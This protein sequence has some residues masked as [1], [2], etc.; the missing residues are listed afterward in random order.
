MPVGYQGTITDSAFLC[1]LQVADSFFPIGSFSHSYGLETF[2]QE[3]VITSA[4]TLK[5]FMFTYIRYVLAHTDCLGVFLTQKYALIRDFDSIVHLDQLMTALKN[6]YE[7][8][9]AST[10]IG[11]AMLN[12]AQQHWVSPLLEKYSVEVSKGVAHCNHAVVFG[13]I[14][15]IIGLPPL[16]ANLVFLYNT[17]ASMVNAAIKLVPLGQREGQSVLFSL[18]PLII[19]TANKVLELE[20]RDLGAFAPAL[21]I[22]C[23]AHERLYTRLFMS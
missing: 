21:E 1:A 2:V 8:R 16:H 17:A 9:E 5:D 18:H 3:G 14:M 20:E 4:A 22:R 13:L 19:E 7:I 6:S 11:R 10:R 12:I 23:M 15:Q